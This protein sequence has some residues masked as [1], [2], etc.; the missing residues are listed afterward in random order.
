MRALCIQ[1]CL[2][3]IYIY[4]Y[5]QI[6]IY[7]STGRDLFSYTHIYACIL[8]KEGRESNLFIHLSLHVYVYVI[9]IDIHTFVYVYIL[10]INI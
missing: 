5:T 1:I 2:K 9:Y 6:G 4:I 3:Y 7:A 8:Y 10:V